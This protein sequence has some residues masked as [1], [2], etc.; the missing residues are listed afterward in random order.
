MASRYRVGRGRGWQTHQCQ[1]T[2][3]LGKVGA[4][5]PDDDLSPEA[6]HLGLERQVLSANKP[7]TRGR[8]PHQQAKIAFCDALQASRCRT[9]ASTYSESGILHA[10]RRRPA[11]HA[12]ST[13]LLPS[14]R[15]ASA[16]QN[17]YPRRHHRPTPRASTRRDRERIAD[18]YP[19][20]ALLEH[21]QGRRGAD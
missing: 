7:A 21:A 3:L 5:L 12:L 15:T 17:R 14:T 1:R 13:L 19:L 20:R 11:R 10:R 4:P 6:I 8:Y 2:I 9:W 16:A 18:L